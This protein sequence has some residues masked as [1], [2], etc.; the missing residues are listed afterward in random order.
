MR[1]IITNKNYKSAK[2][3]LI[4]VIRVPLKELTGISQMRRIHTDRK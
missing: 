3:C 1:R 2:I 4:R